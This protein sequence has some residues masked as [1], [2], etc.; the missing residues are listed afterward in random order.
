PSRVARY[1]RVIG[2][3][4]RY[5]RHGAVNRS[6]PSQNAAGSEESGVRCAGVNASGGAQEQWK[7]LRERQPGE[8]LEGRGILATRLADGSE[9]GAQHPAGGYGVA[10]RLRTLAD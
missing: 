6:S 8:A 3:G 2:D 1:A 10:H 5:L 7:C 4:A 9:F